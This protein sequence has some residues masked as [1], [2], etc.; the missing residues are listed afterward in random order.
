[1]TNKR[2]PPAPDPGPAP[3]GFRCTPASGRAN[4]LKNFAWPEVPQ[5]VGG[6]D[7]NRWRKRSSAC[8]LV[9]AVAAGS[10]VDLAACGSPGDAAQPVG[11]DAT[12]S[13]ALSDAA[14]DAPAIGR[15]GDAMPAGCNGVTCAANETC[16]GGTCLNACDAAKQQESSVGCDYFA[17]YMDVTFN[18]RQVDSC[19][20]VFVANTWQSAV[21]IVAS[22]AG[23]PIDLGQY[24]VIPR[25]AG[26]TLTYTPYDPSAGLPAGMVAILFLADSDVQPRQGL[27][28]YKCP[29]LLD[30]A[31]PAAQKDSVASVLGTGR[32]HAFHV[33]TDVPV[34]SYQILP[35]GG[36]QS[37]VTGATLLIPTSAWDTNYIV[38]SPSAQSSLSMVSPSLDVVAER[39]STHV[40]ILPKAAIVGGTGVQGSAANTPITYTLSAGEMLQITQPQ[41]LSGSPIQ[42][43]KPIGVWGGHQCLTVPDQQ[44][45]CD[46]AE[47]QFPPVRALGNEYAAVSHRPRTPNPENTQWRIVGAV[48]GT[49]LTYEPAISGAPAA[50]ALGQVS[51][52]NTDTPF[53]AK[54]QD[55]KHPFILTTYMSGSGAVSSLD[56]SYLGYG[57]PDW[58]RVVTPAQY[59]NRYVFFTDPT[60]PETNLVV[61]R[62]KGA[63]GFAA[64]T[65]DC[66][67]VL[68]NWQGIGSGGVYEYTRIDL[69]RHDYQPQGGCDNGRHE[70]SSDEPFGLG[71]GVGVRASRR[72]RGRPIHTCPGCSP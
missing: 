15:F 56:G 31:V 41:D 42:S 24:A 19:F 55:D 53:V 39:D 14:A 11:E 54:S 34:V 47:Q 12:A 16:L 28:L 33:Q 18:D 4:L 45:F 48:D 30:A 3:D 7:E 46:H 44:I 29:A 13:D 21:H 61:V 70:M 27:N 67:G 65:L 9:A 49:T 66:A 52:F 32:G 72:R 26:K 5:Q 6:F 60:Y 22:F 36:G 38:V 8:V 58:V 50:L 64:V 68:G 2:P 62:S 17:T 59:L 10:S 63:S 69:V 51:D 25:G 37:A 23:T 40:T 71:S 20:A 35:Y 43:D 1:M 57:D